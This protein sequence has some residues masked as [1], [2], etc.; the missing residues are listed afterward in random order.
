M[1]KNTLLQTTL[2]IFIIGTKV[3]S[4]GNQIRWGPMGNSSMHI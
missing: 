4:Q 2:S 1:Q 3:R